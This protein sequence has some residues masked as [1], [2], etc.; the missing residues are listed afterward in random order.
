MKFQQAAESMHVPL[1]QLYTNTWFSV[2]CFH[3]NHGIATF[4]L[5][6]I[7]CVLGG[8]G[9]KWLFEG[10]GQD[11]HWIVSRFR[12]GIERGYRSENGL[13]VRM[14]FTQQI[15]GTGIVQRGTGIAEQN[16]N[17]IRKLL[18]IFIWKCLVS[19]KLLPSNWLGEWFYWK[20]LLEYDNCEAG[21]SA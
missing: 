13:S 2:Y 11:T 9:G 12:Q 3:C 20:L 14:G 8:I 6:E 1:L 7:R 19:S 16:S 17:Q 15:S 10:N 4:K 21:S 5:K 18:S